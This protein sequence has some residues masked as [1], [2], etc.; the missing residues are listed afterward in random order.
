MRR[1]VLDSWSPDYGSSLEDATDLVGT[2]A[3]V[4]VDVEPGRWA[5][6]GTG[7]LV[8]ALPVCAFLD[9]VRR[10]DARLYLEQDG[11]TSGPASGTTPGAGDPFAGPLADPTPD[12]VP[13]LAGSWA[14][15]VCVAGEDHAGR[16][17]GPGA[18]IQEI[19]SGR[20]LVVG[21]GQTMP[22]LDLQAGDTRLR[23]DVHS[24][25][26]TEGD[27][28]VGVLQNEMRKSEALLANT[29][30]GNHQRQA[31]E[32]E[33]LLFLDGPLH[34]G[35]GTAP[36]IGCIK[37]QAT[38]YLP[39]A[40]SRLLGRLAAGTRTPLF[41]I[42]H[43]HTPRYSWYVRLAEQG[44]GRGMLSGLM[45]CEVSTAVS[46]DL[47]RRLADRSAGILPRVAS[48]PHADPRAPQNLVPI[49]GLE[50]ELKRR[51]GD[52]TMVQRVLLRGIT[53]R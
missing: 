3:D 53:G 11:E 48:S 6:R 31:G 21:G 9:G 44:V 14:V 27:E 13:A 35:Y 12:I 41:E 22:T 19:L 4:R 23:Y 25:S 47:A 42:R 50:R 46:L 17:T 20:V 52:S 1:L 29:W 49:G 40:E 38:G 28:L 2:S 18:R 5:A 34:Q 16:A 32:A 7:P 37:R 45:R 26:G 39:A 24:A 33:V 43:G 10:V 36:V 30:V 15:G 8:G 51:L